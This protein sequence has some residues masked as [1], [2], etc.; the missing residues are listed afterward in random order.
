MP[1]DLEERTRGQRVREIAD[2]N[3]QLALIGDDAPVEL[4]C[5]SECHSE[6]QPGIWAGASLEPPPRFLA[7]CGA[8]NDTISETS[9]RLHS[10]HLT[11]FRQRH[12]A[13]RFHRI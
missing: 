6:P 4:P 1:I 8:G 5:H 3:H 7:L 12:D 9:R 2:S 13:I 10:D 11:L